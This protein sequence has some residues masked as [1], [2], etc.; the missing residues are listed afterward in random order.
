MVFNGNSESKT[1]HSIWKSIKNWAENW[2]QIVCGILFDLIY[3]MTSSASTNMHFMSMTP[4][5]WQEAGTQ[6]KGIYSSWTINGLHQGV[7]RKD[8]T[9]KNKRARI[10]ISKVSNNI[11]VHISLSIQLH[12]YFSFHG[13]F[14]YNYIVIELCK[15]FSCHSA[16]M[17]L[18]I[19]FL[20]N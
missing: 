6:T 8:I 2:C 20:N 12:I 5:R 14:N 1:E 13:L 15:F 11:Q 19:I 17:M 7:H 9:A 4:G 3:S 16:M 10:E 18:F